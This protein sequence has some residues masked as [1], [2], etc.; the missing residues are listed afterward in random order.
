MS[1]ATFFTRAADVAHKS[2]VV[3]LFTFF[4]FQAYQI[5]AKVLERKV[6]SPY[7][8]STYF[9]DVEQK[10]KEE[11]RKDNVVDHRDWYQAEDDS[12]L[13]EQIRADITRPDF[14]KKWEEQRQREGKAE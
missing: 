6:D 1:K 10:V 8:H 14:K 4:G 11:Y 13:K 2:F 5:G 9:K 7:M 12:Y 3:G